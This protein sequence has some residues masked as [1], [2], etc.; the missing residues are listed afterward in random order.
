MANPQNPNS[1]DVSDVQTQLGGNLPN[2]SIKTLPIRGEK[3]ILP[4]PVDP[5]TLSAAFATEWSKSG[6]KSPQ[7]KGYKNTGRQNL[8]E[9]QDFYVHAA[10]AP[11]IGNYVTIRILNRGQGSTG[12][13]DPSTNAIYRFLINPA[14]AQIN[15][16]TLDAQAFAR[17]GW[18]FGVWGE[19]S[20]QI[21][22][23]GKTAGQY[24]AF[25]I[26]DRY[27]EFSQSYRNLEQLQVV[28]ENNG[29]WFEGE[30]AGEGPLAAD[31]ARRRI[32][33]HQD[34]ELTVGNFIWRG[35]FESLELSQ[36]A[37]EPWL[38]SF[39]LVFI[40]WKERFRSASPYQNQIQNDLQRGNAYS[41]YAAT[42][43]QGSST[44]SGPVTAAL[45]STASPVGLAPQATPNVNA[46]TPSVAVCTE[47]GDFPSTS[48][49]V[50]DTPTPP[51]VPGS[52]GVSILT[53]RPQ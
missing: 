51:L 4:I 31:W 16:T 21:T 2:S 10:L 34:V 6:L 5:N 45:S 47:Y 23:N 43:V 8:V 9:A 15:R 24:F 11:Y 25:G 40:A 44:Q 12:N 42:Q 13:P 52:G 39:T 41:A 53:G 48:T 35:M 28:F 29:Y 38:M 17:G 14:Q 30:K 20:I 7:A 33:M 3:R 22:L 46:S 18:Q 27:Q 36:D 19:D 32:K 1:N 26:T 49:N 37:E 50:I